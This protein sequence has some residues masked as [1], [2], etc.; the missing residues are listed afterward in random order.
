M[1]KIFRGIIRTNTWPSEWSVEHAICLKKSKA[2]ETESDVR[3]ISLTASGSK[4]MEAFMIQWLDEAIGNKFD[5]SQYGGLKG[6]S[7]VHYLIELVNFILY[8][9]DLANPKATLGIMYDFCKAFNNQDH[10][11]LIIIL[12][13]MGT[14]G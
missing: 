2:P 11:T 7:T 5:F 3:L 10:N 9:Q 1:G 8:N 6:H 13:D 4:W 14:P 12:S